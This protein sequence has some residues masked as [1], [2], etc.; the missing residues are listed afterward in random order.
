M[1][2]NIVIIVG[3]SKGIG[4]AVFDH[5]STKSY[6]VF[7]LSRSV[8]KKE[9][10]LLKIDINSKNDLQKLEEFLKENFFKIIGIV[11]VAGITKPPVPDENSTKLQTIDDFREILE[12]NLI[13]QY[14]LILKVLKYIEKKAS[15]IFISSIAAA[16]GF[17]GNPG[18]LASKSAI[19]GLTRALSVDLSSKEIR[20]NCI[21][22]GYFKT[23][24]NKKSYTNP[25]IYRKRS[26]G[27][28][29]NRW[30]DPKEVGGVV[31]FLLNSNSSYISG[32]VISVDGGWQIKSF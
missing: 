8:E 19:E 17:P 10:K 27:T 25:E 4:K 32:T 12:T 9:Q 15:I 20:V 1:T 23:E 16:Q 29:L 14:G 5:L 13:S 31:E 30:G 11:F 7:G 18:Y 6:K 26:S 21:R 28:L 24:M 2:K 22:L 3:S